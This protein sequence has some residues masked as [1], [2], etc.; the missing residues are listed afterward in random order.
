[1]MIMMINYHAFENY[2]EVEGYTPLK[3]NYRSGLTRTDRNMLKTQ[4]VLVNGVKVGLKPMKGACHP[5]TSYFIPG[6]Y[7][8]THPTKDASMKKV[9]QIYQGM[10]T[11]EVSSGTV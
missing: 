10:A 8:K 4:T 9:N 6:T 1:M 3:Q 2:A 5:H 7:G 11:S